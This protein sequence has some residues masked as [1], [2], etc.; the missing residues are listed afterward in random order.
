MSNPDSLVPFEKGDPRI[1][2]K[3]RP[4][5]NF[6]GFRN[7]I[8]LAT[9]K[10]ELLAIIGRLK[11]SRDVAGLRLYFEYMYGKVP[12]E[13]DVKENG[14]IKIV[15]EYK[16]TPPGSGDIENKGVKDG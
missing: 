5:S 12:D 2:R 9:S 7:L 8:R 15:V 16:G 1:N 6:K 13:L 4:P 14:K 10:E 11:N 3:G